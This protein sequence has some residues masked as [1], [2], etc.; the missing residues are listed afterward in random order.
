MKHWRLSDVVSWREPDD[1]GCKKTAID[2]VAD[3]DE[4]PETEEAPVSP[5]RRAL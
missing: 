1:S 5:G 3:V 2:D 4:P